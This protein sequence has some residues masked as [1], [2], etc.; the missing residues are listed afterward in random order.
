MTDVSITSVSD[1]ARAMDIEPAGDLERDVAAI[2]R[3]LDRYTACGAT[4]R[5]SRAAAVVFAVV[6]GEDD[7]LAAAP[8][9][10]PFPFDAFN[11]AI[12][13]VEDEADRVWREAGGED[14]CADD[15]CSMVEEA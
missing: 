15:D 1:L 3:A 8:L 13:W 2:S 14:E 9:R 5:A 10:F 7:P 12:R 4:L 11:R 6:E